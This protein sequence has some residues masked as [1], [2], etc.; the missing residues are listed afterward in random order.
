MENHKQKKR[1]KYWKT[2]FKVKTVTERDAY[3][4]EDKSLFCTF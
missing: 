3:K 4:V 1:K 2:N